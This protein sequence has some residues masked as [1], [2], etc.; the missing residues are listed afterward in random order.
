M[1]LLNKPFIIGEVSGNHNKSLVRAIEH[2]RCAAE[3]GC[4]AV[5]FQTFEPKDIA[6]DNIKIPKGFNKLHDEWI[7]SLGVN[8]LHELM[9]KGGLPREYHRELF[10]VSEDCGIEFIST[11]FSVDAAKFLV[12]DIGVKT[13]KVASGDLTFTP[14]LEYL[15]TIPE[16]SVI[17]S[18]GMS[19]LDEILAALDVLKN[20]RASNTAILHCVSSYPCS[21]DDTNIGAISV[22]RFSLLNPIGYSDHTIDTLHVPSAAIGAGA[23]ILEKHFRIDNEST[24]D[25]PHSLLPHELK[26][27]VQSA[28]LAYRIVGDRMKKPRRSEQHDR[29]WAR[30]DPSDWLRPT[31]LGRQGVWN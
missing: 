16:I 23:V 14:L 7:D 24:I 30:R 10:K 18:T 20:R 27:Y 11:P 26:Q 9:S 4:S 6:A 12:E 17:L 22:M 29:I 28:N 8:Y 15:N 19:F 1:E 21:V 3:S 31:Q 2:V 25:S 13:I 5:K